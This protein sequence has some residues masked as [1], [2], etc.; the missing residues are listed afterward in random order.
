MKSAKNWGLLSQTL[1]LITLSV[2]LAGCGGSSD[3]G[4]ASSTDS[5]PAGASVASA[6]PSV[7]GTPPLAVAAENRYSFQPTL[8]NPSGLPVS[9]SIVNKPVWA[10]FG[11]STGELSGTPAAAQTGSYDNI[12]ISA[13][14]GSATSALPA[15]SIKVV[16]PGTA[17][18]AS[19]SS[20]SSSGG[21]SSSSGASTTSASA[22]GTMIPSATQIIDSAHNVWTVAGGLIYE[23]GAAAGVSANVSLLLYYGVTIYQQNKSCLWWSW[24]GS[25]WVATSNPAPS[26]TPACSSTPASAASTVPAA[27]PVTTSSSGLSVRVQSNH[28]VDANGNTLQLRG[29]NISA[30][31]F[32]AINNANT[33]STPWGNQTGTATPQWSIIANTWKANAVRLP[34][35]QASWLGYTCIN[36]SGATINPDPWGNYKATVEQAVTAANAAGLYVI[37]DLHWSAPGNTCPQ[38]QDQMADQDHS[39]AFWTSV[40]NTFKGNPAVL[41]DLFNEPYVSGGASGY[42]NG[43]D[44]WAIWLNGGTTSQLS[45]NSGNTIIQGS[46][47]SVGMNQMIAA[48]RA[49]GATN[50]VMAGGQAGASDLSGWLSHKPTDALN[51]LALSW[52]AYGGTGGQG[53]YAQAVLG[54]GIPVIIGETGDQSSNGT[55]GAP[56]IANVTQWADAN[57]ASVMAWCWDDWSSTGGSANLLIKD[58]SG[59]PTD[60]E[61]VAFKAWMVQH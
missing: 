22:S 51:Q 58:A 40:A 10:T 26:I 42:A 30:L 31:E 49:T 20:S 29:V 47:N 38:S 50:V 28:L 2:A 12:V 14:D 36:S 54:A 7:S 34:L 45:V 55:T 60:G 17:V 18:A 5:T 27:A 24:S 44:Y 53:A 15:F 56:V 4:S 52:H 1:A 9:F 43:A 41:F 11:P 61:G 8:V 23:N 35:N 25:T 19:S 32:I 21:S 48:V 59:T 13:S 57:D 39:L 33:E 6:T 46:W 3:A 37:L 16:A